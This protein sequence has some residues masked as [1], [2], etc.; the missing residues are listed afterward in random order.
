[1]VETPFQGD[2][3]D[4]SVPH[5]ALADGLSPVAIDGDTITLAD[6][7][8]LAV[9]VTVNVYVN[10]TLVLTPTPLY[11]SD[12]GRW[13]VRFHLPRAGRML[14]VFAFDVGGFKMKRR[15]SLDVLQGL[16]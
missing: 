12:T 16:G 13:Y 14:V 1:M 11:N 3:W 4:F 6:D 15:C 7:T 8:D 2:V 5:A 9:L 10:R